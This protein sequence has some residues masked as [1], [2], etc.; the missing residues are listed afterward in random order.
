MVV[1]GSCH[2]LK[3]PTA[4]FHDELSKKLRSMGFRPSKAD[5]DLWMKPMKDHHEHIAT[6]VDD[7]LV[8]LHN[9]MPIIEE[10]CKT[11][12]LKG[13]GIPECC[14]GGDFHSTNNLPGVIEANDDDPSHNLCDKWLKEDIRMAFL[15]QTCIENMTD[16][17]KKMLGVQDFLK[18]RTPMAESAHPEL[19]DSELLNAEEQMQV[20][21]RM[22][23]MAGDFRMV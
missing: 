19:D 10:I 17:M 5:F 14:L 2:G 11:F 13:V 9:P 18:R 21:D 23:T 4:R 12:D 22:F 1:E 6:C 3:T 7:V 16:W 8:F 15:A 20:H